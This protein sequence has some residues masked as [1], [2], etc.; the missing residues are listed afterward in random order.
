MLKIRAKGLFLRKNYMESWYDR[1]L[2]LV[3][4]EGFEKLKSSR[5]LIA[6]LGGVGGYAAE[7]I[8]RAGIGKITLIDGDT[9]RLSNINR[10]LIA[11]HSNVGNKKALEWKKRIADINPDAEV[12]IFDSFFTAQ[13]FKD[14]LNREKFDFVI[15]AIDT[16][17]P[18]IV[19]IATLHEKG[20][21]FVSSMGTGG[22]TDVTKIKVDDISKT[23]NCPL[24]RH[25]R[26]K[27]HKNGIYSGFKAV[28]SFEKPDKK[29][30]LYVSE[31][32]KKTTLGT[33]SYM[34]AIFGMMAA[35]VAISYLLENK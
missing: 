18:K 26:K 17:R 21:P 16:L 1:T 24:A 32:N 11:L 2:L 9:V 3:G 14:L 33:I 5:V 35:G 12:E 20:I 4:E 23:F 13:D 8:A 34:P 7:S 25:L 10:Q 15:D 28:F 6:G 27:L 19:L 22:R 31:Q 30:L 29:T